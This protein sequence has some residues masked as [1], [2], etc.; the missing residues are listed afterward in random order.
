VI[1]FLSGVVCCS[2]SN[3]IDP[4][5]EMWVMHCCSVN[6]AFFYTKSSGRLSITCSIIGQDYL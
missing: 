4:Y 6:P 3:I 1:V 5:V 2:L